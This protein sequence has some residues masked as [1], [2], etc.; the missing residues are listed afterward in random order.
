MLDAKTLDKF[1]EEIN[2]SYQQFCVW[3]YLNDEF[4]LRQHKWKNEMTPINVEMSNQDFGCKFKNFFP[5]TVVSLRDGWLLSLSRICDPAYHP[6][7]TRKE[8]PRLSV[9][10]IVSNFN[11]KEISSCVSEIKS[12]YKVGGLKEYRDNFLTH[13]DLKF[14]NVYIENIE[15]L[16][17]LLDE[18]IDKVKDTN[19]GY[20]DCG[21][22][23]N[24]V[25]E[26]SSRGVFELFEKLDR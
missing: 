13:N 20:L 3:R 10:F 24:N 2:K 19:N 7:D 1:I 22:P 17:Y 23:L 5:V 6:S 21:W 18:L 26:L 15:I 9:D 4:G 11:D 16:Y 8:R 14:D 25:E 12:R